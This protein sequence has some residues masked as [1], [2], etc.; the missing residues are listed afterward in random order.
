MKAMIKEHGDAYKRPYRHLKKFLEILPNRREQLK[1][2]YMDELFIYSNF[3]KYIEIYGMKSCEEILMA[4]EN[5]SEEEIKDLVKNSILQIDSEADFKQSFEKNLETIPIDDAKKWYLFRAYQFPKETMKEYTDLMREF[6]PKFN[7][8]YDEL[9][10][11][12]ENFSR[13]LMNTLKKEKEKFFYNMWD[14]LYEEDNVR[15]SMEDAKKIRRIIISY[16]FSLIACKSSFLGDDLYL[17]GRHILEEKENIVNVHFKRDEHIVSF[18][19]NLGD[20]SRFRVLLEVVK[21][22]GSNMNIAKELGISTATIS[23]HLMNL[24]DSNIIKRDKNRKGVHYIFNKVGT[25]KG[26]DA[27]MNYLEKYSIEDQ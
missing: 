14:G 27:L 12:F 17:L 22:N 3:R 13:E 8:I 4:F 20:L 9:E 24:Q 18:F 26:L 16:S 5:L 6:L 1:K 2:F 23:Y 15:V 19:K 25:Q 7:E 10:S 11:D 21:G